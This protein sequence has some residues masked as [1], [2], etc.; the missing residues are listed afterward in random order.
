ML[1]VRK[2][3]IFSVECECSSESARNLPFV[4][5]KELVWHLNAYKIYKKMLLFTFFFSPFFRRR[6][7][8]L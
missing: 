8:R 6:R 3:E 4:L 5:Y 2:Y 1:H 7:R